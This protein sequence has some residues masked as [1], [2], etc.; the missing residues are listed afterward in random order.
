MTMSAVDRKQMNLVMIRKTKERKDF[1]FHSVLLG[2]WRLTASR[3]CQ[4]VNFL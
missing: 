4:E 1:N 3:T 2:K